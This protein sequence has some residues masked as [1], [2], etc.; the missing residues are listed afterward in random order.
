MP[1]KIK[2][3]V[4]AFIVSRNCSFGIAWVTRDNSGTVIEAES[5]SILVCIQSSMA[6]AIGVKE[7]LGCIK[8]NSYSKIIIESDCQVVV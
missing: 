5:K 2:V 8:Q 4:N 3:N 1:N 7:V 6:E